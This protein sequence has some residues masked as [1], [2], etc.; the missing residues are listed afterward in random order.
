[1]AAKPRRRRQATGVIK[2]E[3]ALTYS[4]PVAGALLGLSRNS[5]YTAAQKGEIPT[6]RIGGKLLVPKLKFH[7]QFEI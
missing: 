2:D 5:A 7:Q 1:M 4:V 3:A 6:I